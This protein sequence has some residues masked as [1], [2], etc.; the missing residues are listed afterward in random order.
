MCSCFSLVLFLYEVVSP[1][2]LGEP[3]FNFL[4]TLEIKFS[5]KEV[6]F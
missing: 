6:T 1:K 4:F 2:D 5:E 3:L